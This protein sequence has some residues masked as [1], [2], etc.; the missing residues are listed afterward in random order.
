MSLA[1][2]SSGWSKAQSLGIFHLLPNCFDLF[3]IMIL[4]VKKGLTQKLYFLCRVFKSGKTGLNPINS[5]PKN[6]VSNVGKTLN[7]KE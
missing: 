6:N 5:S 1:S 7:D 3:D 2:R 4:Q